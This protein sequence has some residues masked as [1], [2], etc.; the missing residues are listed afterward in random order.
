MLVSNLPPE[1]ALTRALHPHSGW[2]T[3]HELMAS[4]IEA[5]DAGMRALFSALMAPH[6]KPGRKPEAWEPI[7]VPRPT[8]PPKRRTTLADIRSRFPRG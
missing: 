5:N 4:I 6:L 8:D 3:E 2:R 7:R 1:S